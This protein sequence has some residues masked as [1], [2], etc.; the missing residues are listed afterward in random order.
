M[1]M[2]G[3][4][5]GREAIF[6][7]IK[8]RDAVSLC[9]CVCVYNSE[10]HSVQDKLHTNDVSNFSLTSKYAAAFYYTCTRESKELYVCFMF[11]LLPCEKGE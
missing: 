11:I 4:R 5:E 2:E 6:V 1:A 3:G 8:G 10:I 7:M 9:V